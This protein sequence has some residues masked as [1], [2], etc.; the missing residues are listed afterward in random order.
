LYHHARQVQGGK[1]VD[2]ATAV[3][4]MLEAKSSNSS[5][6]RE[7]ISKL[8]QRIGDAVFLHLL[9]LWDYAGVGQ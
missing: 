9:E 3:N 4:E 7:Q 8:H 6:I 2:F 1:Q 5:L